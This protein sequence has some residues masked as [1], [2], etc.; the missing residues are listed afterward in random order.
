MGGP[1]SGTWRT[2]KTTVESCKQIDIRFLRRQN[3]LIVGS[4]GV[5]SWH[6]GENR[7]D[8]IGYFVEEGCLVLNY[9]CSLNNKVISTE[10]LIYLT[11]TQCHYGGSRQ[12]FCCPDCGHRRE[13]LYLVRC[14]FSCRQCSDLVYQCQQEQSIDRNYRQAKKIREKF[15]LPWVCDH[16]KTNLIPLKPKGMHRTTFEQL[17]WKQSQ[18]INSV[19]KHLVKKTLKL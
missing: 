17:K 7:V 15:N 18:Y 3:C 14:V 9:D 1:G 13:I 11:E 2:G 16:D 10:Q 5:L 6:T 4:Q 19:F 8:T 12:W